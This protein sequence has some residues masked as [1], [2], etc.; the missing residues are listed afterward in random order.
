[1]NALYYG[2]KM[3]KPYPDDT[4]PAIPS[5]L[6]ALRDRSR[7]ISL[8]GD[9]QYATDPGNEGIRKQYFAPPM[10]LRNGRH[11]R[12]S[13]WYVKGL[14]YHGVVWFRRDIEVPASF[15]GSVAELNFGAVDYEARVW[16]NGVYVGRHIGAYTSFNVNV[17]AA[18]HKGGQNSHCS[19]R[20]LSF[21]SRISRAE[22]PDQG[23]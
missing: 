17:T 16:V 21:R 4:P 15:P 9:W 20:G 10:T 1:M 7:E 11:G 13:Q 6:D 14:D 2:G 8:D 18:L 5:P 23:K 12:P 19:S 3:V 22:N